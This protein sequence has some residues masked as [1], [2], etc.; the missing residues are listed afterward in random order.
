MSEAEVI[1]MMLNRKLESGSQYSNLIP[2]YLSIKHSFELPAEYSDTYETLEYMAYWTEKYAN[3]FQKVANVLKGKNVLETVKNNYNFLYKHFQYKIDESL[4]QIYAP[5]AAWHFRKV[6]FD[7][8]TF[9]VLASALLLCQNIEH[10]FVKVKLQGSNDWGHVYVQIPYQG[11]YLI[12]DATTHDNK[13]VNFI[14]KHEFNMKN[15]KHIGL[16]S[17][18]LDTPY[19]NLDAPSLACPGQVCSCNSGLSNPYNGDPYTMIQFESTPVGLNA[20]SFDSIKSYIQTPISC[21]G[22]SAFSGSQANETAVIIG[23]FFEN[24]LTNI[25]L[26]V[27]TINVEKLTELDHNFNGYLR[28]GL[29]G[30]DKKRQE[31][32]NDCTEDSIGAMQN[33][34][35]FY[36]KVVWV[37]YDAWINKYFNVTDVSTMIYTN[38]NIELE[39]TKFK[40]AFTNPACEKVVK[41]RKFQLKPGVTQIPEFEFTPYVQEVAANP[42]SFDVVKFLQGLTTVLVSFSPSSGTVV[43]ENGNILTP[44]PIK[45]TT[46]NAGM[47]VLFGGL[48][49]TGLAVWG[50]SKMKD[51]GKGSTT[52]TTKK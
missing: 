27:K 6:G 43:D 51:S 9:S 24:L 33:I 32:W 16:A 42:S 17:P 37:G 25:N 46:S 28:A 29:C 10:S 41:I 44:T 13:E 3:Q 50:F 7:C 38:E 40:F 47:G 39:P 31:G 45:D 52:K 20:I 48:A 2:N 11:S 23:A 49:L 36:Q 21:W 8:K 1:N 22:G 26:A 18:Y 5:S 19:L 34:L 12:I 4:Q 35:D 14:E 30:Y 15:L